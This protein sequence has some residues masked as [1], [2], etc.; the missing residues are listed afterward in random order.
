M[1][2]CY[3]PVRTKAVALYHQT[4]RGLII[5]SA[6]TGTDILHDMSLCTWTG[7]SEQHVTCPCARGQG[8][9]NNT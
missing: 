1:R 6:P 5:P 8:H 9:Q 4:T 2:I 3:D 7:T